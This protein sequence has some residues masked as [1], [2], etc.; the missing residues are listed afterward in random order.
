M[1]AVPTLIF[2]GLALWTAVSFVV[3]VV[4]GHALRRLEPVPV[5][6]RAHRVVDIRRFH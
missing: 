1:A 5:R 3:A 6:A 2:A 4:L